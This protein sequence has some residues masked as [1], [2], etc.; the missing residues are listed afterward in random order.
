MEA[1]K[2]PSTEVIDLTNIEDDEEIVTAVVTNVT[3]GQLLDNIPHVVYR[4]RC[5]LRNCRLGQL[6]KGKHVPEHLRPVTPACCPNYLRFHLQCFRL[7]DG[8]FTECTHCRTLKDA[9]SGYFLY[10]DEDV[11]E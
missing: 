9:D 3:G 10:C 5:Y 8:N 6:V 11:H 7:W 1:N 2:N 4:S